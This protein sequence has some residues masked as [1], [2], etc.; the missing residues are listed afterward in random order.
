[1]F[2]QHLNPFGIFCIAILLM[3]GCAPALNWREVPPAQAG[4]ASVSF[5][6]HPD[7]RERTLTLPGLSG[8]PVAMRVISCQ[9]D[10]ATWALSYFDATTPE[11]WLQAPA[12]WQLALQNNLSAVT[13]SQLPALE[14]HILIG[15]GS[16]SGSTPHPSAS[17]WRASGLRPV[18]RQAS[19]P[20]T[21]NTMYFTKGL[22][23]YQLSWWRR[24]ETTPDDPW[25]TFVRNTHFSP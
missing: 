14:A 3:Q 23:V 1:M 20:V 11:R 15:H 12:L 21:V 18:S 10:S 4:G 24:D 16:I 25:Q 8:A 7:A 9:A 22:R 5:P 17:E 13:Q 6:C 19:E 2:R